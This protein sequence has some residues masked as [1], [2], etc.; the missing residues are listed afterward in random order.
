MHGTIVVTGGTGFIGRNVLPKLV[1][2][3]L[4]VHAFS[5]RA[6]ASK[7]AGCDG[8]N[9]HRVNLHVRDS[10]DAALAEIRPTHL[11]HLAWYAEPGKFWTAPENLDWLAASLALLRAFAR[12]GGRRVV[13]AGTCAEYEWPSDICREDE[14]P[15]RPST[16][17]GV[18][19]DALWRT[20]ESFA[21]QEG[22][23]A[24]WGRIFFLYGPGEH[25]ARL[26]SSVISSLLRGEP[27]LCS[28]GEQRRDFLHVD[29]VASAFA[30][31]V[32]SDVGGAVNIASGEAVPI[33]DVIAKIAAR[34]GRED[35]VRLG[36]RAAPP[37][38]PPV[39]AASVERLH[40]DIGWSPRFDLDRGLDQTIGWWRSELGV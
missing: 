40:R 9:W 7:K 4:A 6:D 22:L 3:G 18:A 10:V 2:A 31:M 25:P 20:A 29:D 1:Q 37:G 30:A 11:L 24:A 21:R 35:L 36:A 13:M 26:V 16:L 17:Y 14:T 19:K 5:S 12:H 34:I 8:V 23:S 27:A 38:D 28:S 32:R 33:K 15:R 39:I